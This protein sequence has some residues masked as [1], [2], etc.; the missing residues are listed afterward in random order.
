MHAADM[1]LKH[2]SLLPYQGLHGT[3]GLCHVR[4]YEQPGRLPAVIAGALEDGPATSITNAIEM[5]AAAIQ[6]SVF[7]DGREFELIEYYTDSIDGAS[8]PSFSRVR[9]TH[10][11]IEENP[12]DPSHYAGTV[13]LIDGE[14]LHT[15]EGP[16][17]EG[18]FRDPS[19]EPITDI[20]QR[21]GFEVEVWEPGSYTARA[22]AGK[23]GQQL[24]Q[25]VA[26]ESAEATAR[27]RELLEPEQ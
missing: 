13:L 18:D 7:S 12:R 24:C 9:F 26:E 20:E 1:R 27:L 14:A 11:S 22:V 6:A 5:V 16:P 4:V 19:W 2:E 15:A 8:S 17:I 3:R 10:R 21:L 25:E 23:Q